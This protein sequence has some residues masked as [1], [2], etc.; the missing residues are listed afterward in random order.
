ME[1]LFES[2]AEDHILL[3]HG[4]YCNADA[5]VKRPSAESI[6]AQPYLHNTIHN[7]LTAWSGT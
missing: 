2:I 3:S 5:R 4:I 1:E 6:Y 7:V